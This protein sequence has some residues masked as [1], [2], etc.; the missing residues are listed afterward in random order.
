MLLWNS[1]KIVVL[2]EVVRVHVFALVPTLQHGNE[3][4]ILMSF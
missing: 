3:D 2:R 1:K 4:I